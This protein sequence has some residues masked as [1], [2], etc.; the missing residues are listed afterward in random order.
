M[1]VILN[2]ETNKQDENYDFPRTATVVAVGLYQ[3]DG[4]RR[5]VW[6]ATRRGEL[7]DLQFDTN[8]LLQPEE[9]ESEE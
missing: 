5:Q 8:S 2:V 3:K 6:S 9:M 7:V 1:Y 4:K